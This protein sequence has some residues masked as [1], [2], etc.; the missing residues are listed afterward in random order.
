MYDI[1]VSMPSEMVEDLSLRDAWR[2]SKSKI[3]LN[4]MSQEYEPL[5]CVAELFRL[6]LRCSEVR[7]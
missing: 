5:T 4:P 2:Y 6:D 1:S 7:G 3:K